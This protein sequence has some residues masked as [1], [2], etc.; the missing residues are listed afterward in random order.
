MDEIFLEILFK[1]SRN[2]RKRSMAEI[3]QVQI[4]QDNHGERSLDAIFLG[5][6]FKG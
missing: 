6:L 2:D 4:S 1:D 5:M 3:F